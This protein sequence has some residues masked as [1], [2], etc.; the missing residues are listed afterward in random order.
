MSSLK[1][2]SF[3]A[4]SKLVNSLRFELVNDLLNAVVDVNIVYG[5]RSGIASVA[6]L[7]NQCRV[8]TEDFFSIRPA[9]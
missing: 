7:P 6:F 3:N 5:V 8:T 2:S 4:P 1:Y 9:G